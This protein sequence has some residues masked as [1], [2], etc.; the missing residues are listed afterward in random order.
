MSWFFIPSFAQHFFSILLAQEGFIFIY[1]FIMWPGSMAGLPLCCFTA[2]VGSRYFLIYLQIW[3]WLQRN[4]SNWNISKTTT[5]DFLLSH[6]SKISSDGV[7]CQF[8]GRGILETR[9]WLAVPALIYKAAYQVHPQL[10]KTC[11]NYSIKE[12]SISM[13]KKY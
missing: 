13:T 3:L 9:F 11:L 6:L 4:Y 12:R 7:E 8:I 1:S 10:W 5:N 2:Q